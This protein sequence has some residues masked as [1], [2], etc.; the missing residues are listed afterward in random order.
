[1]MSEFT[2]QFVEKYIPY[3]FLATGM[4]GEGECC[5]KWEGESV[6]G[7]KEEVHIMY[8]LGFFTYIRQTLLLKPQ[9][10]QTSLTPTFEQPKKH[11][12]F[13]NFKNY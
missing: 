10:K 4:A 5:S 7:G 2:K 13:E 3:G 9:I 11:Y 12:A 8:R 6:L 1:M